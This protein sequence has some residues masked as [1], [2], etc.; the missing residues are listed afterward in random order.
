MPALGIDIAGVEDVDLFL[1]F[2]DPKLAAAQ[3]V[4]RSLTH[5][6][7][8]LWWAPESGHDLKQH[9]NAFAEPERIATEVQAQCEREERVASAQ[10][11]ASLLGD[12]LRLTINLILEQDSSKVT[13]TVTVNSL[14]EILDASI[15]V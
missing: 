5:A 15:V 10:V 6:P 2:A 8:R 7:G 1:S 4:A 3:A 13:L 14:G 12:E 11:E 9:L